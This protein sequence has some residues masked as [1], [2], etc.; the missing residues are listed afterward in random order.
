MLDYLIGRGF[1]PPRLSVV[2]CAGAT[3]ALEWLLARGLVALDEPVYPRKGYGSRTQGCSRTAHGFSRELRRL[4]PWLASAVSQHAR[5]GNPLSLGSVLAALAVSRGALALVELL[6]ARGVDS[7]PRLRL[8]GDR[9]LLHVVA[10]NAP[11]Y[12]VVWLVENGHRASLVHRSAD[13]TSP[14][15]EAILAG[16][17][18]IVCHLL[19]QGGAAADD[20]HDPKCIAWD[21]LGVRSKHE[22]IRKIADGHRAERACTTLLPNILRAQEGSD[23]DMLARL[24]ALLAQHAS[25]IRERIG[26]WRGSQRE[27]TRLIRAALDG[28]RAPV[29]FHWLYA[30]S[31]LFKRWEPGIGARV[32]NLDDWRD[33]SCVTH[34]AL[35]R[36]LADEHGGSAGAAPE[37]TAALDELAAAAARAE[38]I[39][40]QLHSLD[41]RLIHLWQVG[42]AVAEIESLAGQ[43]HALLA[44]DPRSDEDSCRA[45]V[46]G[47][48]MS[49][50]GRMRGKLLFRVN[51]VACQDAGGATIGNGN[52]NLYEHAL[53]HFELLTSCALNGHL[54][55]VDYL[56]AKEAAAGGGETPNSRVSAALVTTL[57]WNGPLAAVQA[58]CAYLTR[59]GVDLSAIQRLH[60]ADEE[61][62]SDN[63]RES[64]V[65]VLEN[66]LQGILSEWY[67]ITTHASQ[68]GT[69]SA[70]LSSI[71]RAR[72]D[73]AFATVAWLV[74]SDARCQ[75]AK[76]R[77]GAFAELLG[78][79]ILANNGGMGRPNYARSPRSDETAEK[80]QRERDVAES[81]AL[82]LRLTRLCVEQ[83]GALWSD[84]GPGR[85]RER[86]D[87]SCNALQL[88]TNAGWME[89]VGWLARERGAPLQGL[90]EGEMWVYSSGR[91][92]LMETLRQMQEEQARS[93]ERAEGAL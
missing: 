32:L 81:Q 48:S 8:A 26:S 85:R 82:V 74:S 63:L 46:Y 80:R 15:H 61:S 90:V 40:T 70:P 43:I 11:V 60:D 22:A 53:G 67:L 17:V 6:V 78:H 33:N 41:E 28:G 34:L 71:G 27:Y 58:L 62:S 23:A 52:G 76:L 12:A 49:L 92:S 25:A 1:E 10:R 4:A 2:V 16:H 65:G 19:E 29:F 64:A 31:G 89:A 24:D 44:E 79:H 20:P 14:L 30:M 93:W 50:T 5:A 72:M 86:G 3:W 69:S 38:E 57:E 87:A 47:M 7:M 35:C 83:L 55:L 36:A 75:E 54:H 37:V 45:F 66:A 77:P 9:T 56:L 84:K 13:G 21:E 73:S 51:Q 42:G 18:P 68:C 88:L 91:Q 39:R 59:R